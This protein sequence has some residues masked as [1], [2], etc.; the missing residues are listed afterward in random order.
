MTWPFQAGRPSHRP[1]DASGKRVEELGQ[2]PQAVAG[3]PKLSS[4]QAH[5]TGAFRVGGHPGFRAVAA[6]LQHLSQWPVSPET[7]KRASQPGEEGWLWVM[8]LPRLWG[9]SLPPS[10]P[11]NSTLSC[12]SAP[13]AHCVALTTDVR[14]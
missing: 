10:T 9:P 11:I 14:L 1:S 4:H 6:C 7:P 2:G 13:Q 3:G 12:F 5:P 8:W